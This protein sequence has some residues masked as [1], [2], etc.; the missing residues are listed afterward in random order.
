MIASSQDIVHLVAHV[1]H[2]TGRRFL[3]KTPY[4]RFVAIGLQQFNL[5]IRQLDEYH[6]DAVV[7][8]DLRRTHRGTERFAVGLRRC[9]QVRYDNGY[10]VQASKH[11]FSSPKAYATKVVSTRS[12]CTVTTGRLLKRAL[13]KRRTAV[14]IRS[15]CPSISRPGALA[16]VSSTTSAMSSSRSSSSV[17]VRPCR[18]ISRSATKSPLRSIAALTMT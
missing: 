18:E 16:I 11:V 13:N 6:G 12:K 4:R 14:R 5:G 17:S 8:Q 1:V 2:A 10:V 3:Q 9:R 15:V 7:R